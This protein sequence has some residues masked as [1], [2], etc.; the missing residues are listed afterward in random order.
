MTLRADTT[1]RGDATEIVL[2]GAID[3]NAAQTL[4]GAFARI[5]GRKVR[6]SFR[7]VERINSY[8]ISLLL[9]LLDKNAR[10]HT[11]EFVECTEPI[12]D[13]FQ[14]LDFSRYGRIKSLF[15]LYWCRSCGREDR[16]LVQIGELAITEQ[17]VSA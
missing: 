14:M 2:I 13:Q 6:I 4:E 1:Q 5:E 17:D 9:R 15:V 12:V 7:G 8:G 16:I 3:Q 10:T 11:V